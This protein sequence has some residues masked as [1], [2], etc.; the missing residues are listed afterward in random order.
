MGATWDKHLAA[1]R[2]HD[3]YVL[4]MIDQAGI[5]RPKPSVRQNVQRAISPKMLMRR[6]PDML[7]G[8]IT[9]CGSAYFLVLH[10]RWHWGGPPIFGNLAENL[11]PSERLRGIFLL[12]WLGSMLWLSIRFKDLRN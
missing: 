9:L 5:P 7:A 4:V 11:L 3:V 8:L 10:M 12:L 6:S 1:L 2:N